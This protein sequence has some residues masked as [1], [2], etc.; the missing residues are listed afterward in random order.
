MK[1]ILLVVTVLLITLATSW[2][3]TPRQLNKMMAQ[4]DKVTIIDV[5]STGM[6]RQ[7]HIQGAINIPASVIAK[8]RLPPIGKVVVCGDGVRED[9]SRQAVEALNRKRGIEAE[10]LQG[11]FAAW[12]AL[13]H[14]TTHKGGLGRKRTRYLSYQDFEKAAAGNADI[15][16]VDLRSRQPAAGPSKGPKTQSGPEADQSLTDLNQKF[17]GHSVVQLN[18]RMRAGKN[19]WDVSSVIRK[20]AK[21]SHHRYQYIIID[22]GDG[23]GEKVARRLFA[24]GV[25]RVSILTG[26]ERIL[27]RE[28]RSEQVRKKTG[29]KQN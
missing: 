14:P 26:G 8:K 5:R 6:Y 24:A 21:G 2:A 15:V 17:S 25:K 19:R 3:V 13:N 1:R 7:G 20:N 12:E 23:E 4:G 18:R 22:D 11:G 10:M 27:R 29:R 28:G 9:L 16:L